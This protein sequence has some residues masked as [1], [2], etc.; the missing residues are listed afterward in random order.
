MDLVLGWAGDGWSQCLELLVL[1]LGCGLCLVLVL[2][3]VLV[4]GVVFFLHFSSFLPNKLTKNKSLN[5]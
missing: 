1:V 5:K 2:V 4:W 3:L